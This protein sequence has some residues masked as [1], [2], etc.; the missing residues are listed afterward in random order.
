MKTIKTVLLKQCK[1]TASVILLF[2]LSFM[3]CACQPVDYGAMPTRPPSAGSVSLTAEDHAAA[4]SPATE[5]VQ[6]ILPAAGEE[7]TLSGELTI[8]TFNDALIAPAAKAFM[9][10]YPEVKIT[11]QSYPFDNNVPEKS[12]MAQAEKFVYQTLTSLMS[13]TSS[14]LVFVSGL[15][16]Y[17]LD[18]NGLFYDL[19]SFMEQDRDLNRDSVFEN[20]LKACESG[21]RLPFLPATIEF[22]FVY[23]NSLYRD[24]VPAELFNQDTIDYLTMEKITQE[25]L[26]KY[27]N[28]SELYFTYSSLDVIEK[29]LY[30]F[31]D[32]NEKRVSFDQSFIDFVK[33]TEPWFAKTLR[34]HHADGTFTYSP[35]DEDMLFHPTSLIVNVARNKDANREGA[36]LVT[37]TYGEAWFTSISLMAIP[38]MSSNPTLAWEFIK[39]I[40]SPEWIVSNSLGNVPVR[41]DAFEKFCLQ[42]LTEIF[43]YQVGVVGE[44]EEEAPRLMEKL[45][46]MVSGVTRL[47]NTQYNFFQIINSELKKYADHEKSIEEVTQTLNERLTI[48]VNE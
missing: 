17:K 28:L 21:S 14:D 1:R 47:H 11:V 36:W 44:L 2:L 26:Q 6:T 32:P 25:V 5:T 24:D 31:F 33:L 40:T 42:E 4:S 18:T 22:D 27:P 29:E 13:G 34:S 19:Y 48:L 3:L 41:K 23:L 20:I 12:Y 43:T 45:R 39:F 35:K 16:L 10:L 7:G 15:P 37:N 46:N 30:R 9:E 8:T 38:R